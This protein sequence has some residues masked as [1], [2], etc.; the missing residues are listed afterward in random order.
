M[1]KQVVKNQHYI[2]QSLLRHFADP[3]EKLFEAFLM[4]K[5]IFPTTVANTMSETYTYEYD[6]LPVNTIENF[7]SRIEGEVATGVTQIINVIEE[8]KGGSAEIDKVKNLVEQFL[9]RFLV[10]YYRSGALLT[11]FSFGNKDFKIPLLSEKIL[12]HE[13]INA[14]SESIIKHYDFAIIGS[15]DD[16][17]LSDQFVSTAAIKIKTQFFDISNRHIG[18]RDTIIL[19]PISASYYIVFW[20]TPNSFFLKKDSLLKLESA[21]LNLINKTIINNSYIKVVCKKKERLEEILDSFE[22]RSPT[23]IFAGGNPDGFSMGSIK[24]KEV[25]LFEEE[26]NVYELLEHPFF[27]QYKDL[28]RNDVCTCGSG[29]KFKKCHLTAYQRIQSIMSTFG[30]S[31]RENI[32]DFF[33][34]GIQTIEKPIDKWSGFSKD[35]NQADT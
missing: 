35:K 1:P 20:N 8:V 13:Y 25:F 2:P 10:F 12:N 30:R 14:L 28:G 4:Q 29:K 27:T 9:G 22:H 21:E 31:D 23:Q 18:L 7:F 15:S 17:L 16:F 32:M 24:K 34:Y 26:K 6:K 11:E 33:I 5:K 3:K 19:I